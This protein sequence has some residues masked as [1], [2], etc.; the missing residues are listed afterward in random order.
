MH[1]DG[2]GKAVDEGPSEPVAEASLVV[3]AELRVAVDDPPGGAVNLLLDRD[4]GSESQC[5][6][7][8]A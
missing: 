5:P 3:G 4:V 6:S 1:G 7:D 8:L 2:R